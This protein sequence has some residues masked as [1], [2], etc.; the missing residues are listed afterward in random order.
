MYISS[1][2]KPYL[3][4]KI[5]KETLAEYVDKDYSKIPSFLRKYGYEENEDYSIP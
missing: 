3:L 5:F 4:G 1:T 2:I